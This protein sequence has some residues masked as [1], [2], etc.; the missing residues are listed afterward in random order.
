LVGRWRDLFNVDFDVL[1]YD[2]T[3]TYFEVNA[4][5]LPEATKR[6][7]GYSRDK[8]PDCPQ[9]AIALVADIRWCRPATADGKTLLPRHDRAAYGEARRVWAMD[10]GVPIEAVLRDQLVFTL[11]IALGLAAERLRRTGSAG[12]Q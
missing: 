5:D 3:S 12:E 7:H 8:R 9:V 10:R 2:L 6:R 11:V 4:S 1:L